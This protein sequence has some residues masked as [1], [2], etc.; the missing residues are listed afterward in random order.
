MAHQD[1]GGAV[2]ERVLDGGQRGD[3]ALRIGDGAGDLVLGD[4][5][6]HAHEDAFAGDVE[7]ADGFVGGHGWEQ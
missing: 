7:V 2:V 6:I 5:E 3:D 1:H 4:V